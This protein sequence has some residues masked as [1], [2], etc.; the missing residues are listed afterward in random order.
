MN[1]LKIAAVLIA[2]LVFVS[3]GSA[4]VARNAEAPWTRNGCAYA[5]ILYSERNSDSFRLNPSLFVEPDGRLPNRITYEGRT[6]ERGWTNDGNT[7]CDERLW[8]EVKP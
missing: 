4:R 6:F 1:W 5:V 7:D 8:F 2:P 3:C